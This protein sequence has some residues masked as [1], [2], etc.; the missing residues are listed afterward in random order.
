MAV[1]A[2]LQHARFD[3]AVL[4][5]DGSSKDLYVLVDQ[6]SAARPEIAEANRRVR[7]GT[8]RLGP[9]TFGGGSLQLPIEGDNL[10][11]L[12]LLLERH[13]D[14]EIATEL[15]VR[16]EHGC[17]VEAPDVGDNDIWVS[18]RLTRESTEALR[19]ALSKHL[20]IPPT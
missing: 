13:A 3:G 1:L 11:A 7:E 9:I 14:P 16:D 5:L 15:K 19:S 2:A 18:S 6:R 10:A 12:R 17:L 4:E 20:L 8:R